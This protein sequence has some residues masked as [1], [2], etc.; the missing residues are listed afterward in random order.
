M[1]ILALRS[2]GDYVILLNSIKHAD[3]N[4]D[5]KIIASN[6]LKP[7]HEA[8]SADF[9]TNFEFIFKDFGIKNGLMAFFTNKFFFSFNTIFEILKL[10]NYIKNLKTNDDKLFLEHQSRKFL[11]NLF[12]TKKLH[13]LYKIGNVYDSFGRF[14]GFETIDKTFQL[15]EVRSKNKVL[16]FPDSRKKH[17]VINEETLN[18]LSTLLTNL[19]LDFKIAQ[20]GQINNENSQLKNQIVYKDFKDLIILIKDCDFVIS[21]D[22]VPVHIAEFLEKQHVILYNDKINYN[23][24]TPFAKKYN[25]YTTFKETPVFINKYFNGIC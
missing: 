24:L 7:L 5:V 9:S 12:L 21:S 8:L 10:K 17:K 15:S 4:Q 13:H 1:H 3:L 22:S 19:S 11:L 18:Q 23:W 16:I 14:F 25:M 2:Y 20:F 6:H